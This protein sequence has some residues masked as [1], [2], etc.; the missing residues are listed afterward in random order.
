L[1]KLAC[2]AIQKQIAQTGLDLA[3][4]LEPRTA[5]EMNKEVMS[6]HNFDLAYLPLDY[7]E[8]YSLTG[9]F[10][11][12]ATGRDERNFM[13]YSPDYNM[14]Q[15]LS[16][17][18]GTRNFN[19]IKKISHNIHGSFNEAMPFIPLWQLDFHMIISQKLEIHP[20]AKYVDPLTV[21]DEVESW[22]VNR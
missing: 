7:N 12:N 2:E 3:I 6:E 13:S 18:R 5:L 22:R 16:A 11:V 10:D 9:L 1:S 19:E 4:E 20:S 15:W 14:A 17:I 21:F 8:V